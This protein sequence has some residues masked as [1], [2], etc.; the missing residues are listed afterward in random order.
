MLRVNKELPQ[1]SGTRL[2]EVGY[3]ALSSLTPTY[4]DAG[5][6]DDRGIELPDMV[7]KITE[8]GPDPDNKY[9]TVGGVVD[10][11]SGD[12]GDFASEETEGK[13]TEYLS[14]ARRHLNADNIS[15]VFIVNEIDGKKDIEFFD[16]MD[17]YYNS[18]ENLVIWYVDALAML[19][20]VALKANLRNEMQLIGGN[21]EKIFYPFFVTEA[22][23][24]T[25]VS[26]ITREVGQQVEEGIGKVQKEYDEEYQKRPRLHVIT[27]DVVEERILNF[28]N[29]QGEVEKGLAEYFRKS[30]I[31]AEG[32]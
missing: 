17:D 26:G 2:E 20:E 1:N 8:I 24:Q 6:E 31:L 12:E 27:T 23:N 30:S 22:F 32:Y 25:D 18:N 11:K 5:G 16:K 4:P 29:S 10:A 19:L 28:A 13:H 21:F 3:A 7:F 9:T 14:R 15:H